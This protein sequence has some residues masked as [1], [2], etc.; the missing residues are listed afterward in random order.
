MIDKIVGSCREAVAQVFDG[1]TIMIGGFGDPGVPG[2]LIE[3]L[4]EQGSTDLVIIHN[5]AGS[6]DFSLGGLILDGRVR[7]LIASFPPNPGAHAF[8]DRFLKG[9]IEL[10]LVPQGTL[11]ERIRAAGAGIGGFYTPTAAGTDL[12]A[13]KEIRVLDGRPHVFERPLHAD[14]AFLKAYKADRFGNLSYRKAMR[15]FN[16]IM[17]TAGKTVICEV[18]EI[19]PPGGIPLEEIHTPG[20]FVDHV[21]R[22]ERHPRLFEPRRKG[23]AS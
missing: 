23:A 16:P 18:E 7:K 3:A 22:V 9:E 2:Q 14:F 11:I 5:G 6:G 4:R 1:A 10:E 13:G 8:R 15:N 20:I 17:A 12:A 21:V 19:V